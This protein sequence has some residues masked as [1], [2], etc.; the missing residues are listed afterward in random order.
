MHASRLSELI[1]KSISKLSFVYPNFL[2][3]QENKIAVVFMDNYR[4]GGMETRPRAA[5]ATIMKG[6][7]MLNTK[8]LENAVI[9]VSEPQ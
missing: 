7:I 1:G 3:I 5:I 6:A 8:P 4:N 2:L 9:S